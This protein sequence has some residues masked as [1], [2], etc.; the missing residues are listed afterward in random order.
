LYVNPSS[1]SRG[2]GEEEKEYPANTLT[3]YFAPQRLWYL[4][5]QNGNAAYSTNPDISNPAG[6]TAPAVFY[7][8]GT[9]ALIAEGLVTPQQG[10][11]V[12]MWVVCDEAN[13]HLFSHDDNGRLYRSQTPLSQFPA[14]MSEPVIALQ[15]PNKNDLF[16]AA[17]VYRVDN[18]TY[19]LLVECIGAGDSPGGLR[20]FRSWT[21][22]SIDGA[23]TPLADTQANPFMG[24]AN[25]V[26]ANGNKWT[27]SISH[28]E[29]IRSQVD[30][31]LSIKPCNMRFLYQ[32]LDPGANASYNALPWHLGLVT[33]SGNSTC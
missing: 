8:N 9:P 16:E 15:E 23:W 26:F 25:V 33:Q 18:S 19:L 24:E 3:V 31:T 5:Y 29:I 10:Y 11:W 7:P 21:S 30:Q 28:G 1:P 6:W 14:G 4:I 27:R 13:C 17:N 20:Y 2:P 12:D 32:G 22:P